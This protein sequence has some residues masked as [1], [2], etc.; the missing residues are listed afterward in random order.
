MKLLHV[1]KP[2]IS[3]IVTET[4]IIAE[5]AKLVTSHKCIET[6]TTQGERQS[7]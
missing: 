3:N 1:V 6:L 7:M 5:K 4:M 2:P